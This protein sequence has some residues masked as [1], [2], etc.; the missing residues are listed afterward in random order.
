MKKILVLML[1]LVMVLSVA[2]F[3]ACDKAVTYTGEVS[4]ENYG[5]TYGVK[6]DVT[7][8]GDKITAVKLYTDAE[9]GWVRTSAGWHDGEGGYGKAETDLGFEAAEA[10]Y[11]EYLNTFVG[12]TVAE[13]L[14][15]EATATAESATVTTE[16]WNL[17]GATQSAARIIVAIQ[18]AVKFHGTK[19]VTGE[20]SYANYGTTYGVK[21]DVTVVNGV[22]DAVK[23]YTDAETGWVRTSA[24]WHDGE[25]GYGK[26]ETDLGF[27]AAEAAYPEYLNTFVGKTVAEV[28]AVEATATAES[29]T[30]T[31]E[32]W[33]L[34]GATQSAARI[35]VAIQ[36]ALSK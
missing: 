35:I 32:G 23:L 7:V 11:P 24:G 33:N 17:A 20:V 8:K 31:T 1:A 26:A 19:T 25:G 18:N 13:V 15:V 22:I 29:A 14:A 30:V 12:K 36:N 5:T 27:E 9:T 3:A 2:A 16:G 28:L 4:Y 10:A 6:V 34:A 21:V